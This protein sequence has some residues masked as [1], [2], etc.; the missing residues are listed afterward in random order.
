MTRQGLLHVEGIGEETADAILLYAAGRPTFVVD[1]YTRRVLQRLELHPEERSYE[2]YRRLFMEHLPEDP[3]LYN[4]HH[5]QLV[6]LG[7]DHCRVT[8]RCRGCPLLALCPT[9]QATK[10]EE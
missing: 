2:G 7:K 9:G 1:A 6:Q 10:T 5:A 8:P 3:A 4:E